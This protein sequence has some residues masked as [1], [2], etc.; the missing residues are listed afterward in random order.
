MSESIRSTFLPDEGCV[1]VRV[2]LS[3]IEDRV[4]K[5]ATRAPRMIE[6]ANRRPEIYNAHTDNAA[7]IFGISHSAVTKEQ[8]D[9]GKR[10]V[11]ASQRGMAGKTLSEKLLEDGY[12]YTPKRCQIMIDA[13]LDKNWEIRDIYFPMVRETL[14]RDKQLVNSWG[15]VWDVSH[16]FFDDDLYRR[17]YSWYPQ[18]EDADWLNQYGFKPTYLYLKNNQLRSRINLQVHDEVIVSCPPYEAFEVANYTVSAL[19]Q[20]RELFGNILRVPACV[21]LG[22][23]W[24][25]GVEFKRMPS[26]EEFNETVTRVFAATW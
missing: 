13:Y 14:M 1:F 20:K 10:T 3:Q 5:M 16:E 8:Y 7:V 24:H 17:G 6:L 11:H 19:E 2:D 12:I 9:L 23:N 22:W 21:T 25:E 15:R 4:V 18:S 26:R